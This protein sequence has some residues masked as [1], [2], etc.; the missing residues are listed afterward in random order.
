MKWVNPTTDKGVWVTEIMTVFIL[1]FPHLIDVNL[2]L[3][4]LQKIHRNLIYSTIPL[5]FRPNVINTGVV[6]RHH[7]QLPMA[8]HPPRKSIWAPVSPKCSTVVLLPSIVRPPGSIP[9]HE[10]NIC[11]SEQT[12]VS[13]RWTWMSYMKQ[14]SFR[15]IHEEPHGYMSS[16]ILSWVYLVRFVLCWFKDGSLTHLL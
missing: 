1:W 2:S 16:R 12:R 4:I 3:Y 7:A 11:L 15:C 14:R 5:P 10:I 8:Y 13:L 9:R 6:I